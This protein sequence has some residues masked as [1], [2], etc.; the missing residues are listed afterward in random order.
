MPSQWRQGPP[1][2]LPFRKSTRRKLNAISVVA[3]AA[4]TAV[5]ASLNDKGQHPLL[6]LVTGLA[7]A[8][9]I[10]A[11]VAPFAAWVVLKAY[12][13]PDPDDPRFFGR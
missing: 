5:C 2:P 11:C 13:K 10:A 8:A 6:G 9:L 3:F 7:I 1:G 4:I 12:G